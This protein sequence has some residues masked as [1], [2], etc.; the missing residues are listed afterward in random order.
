MVQPTK[1]K[2]EEFFDALQAKVELDSTWS[3]RKMANQQN[4]NPNTIKTF[5]STDL[6]LKLSVSTLRHLLTV[7]LKSTRLKKYSRCNFP[8]GKLTDTLLSQ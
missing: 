7:V 5:V 6:G 2:L 1:S 4:V 3:M 8:T